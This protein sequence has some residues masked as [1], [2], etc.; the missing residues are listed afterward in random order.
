[1]KKLRHPNILLFMGAVM[2]PQRLCIVSEFLPRY[3]C[4]CFLFCGIFSLLH[5]Y[6]SLA[7]KFVCIWLMVDY[8]N[9]CCI[10][11]GNLNSEILGLV[12]LRSHFAFIFLLEVVYPVK[13]GLV[14]LHVQT[15]VKHPNTFFFV[16]FPIFIL[17]FQMQWKLVSL[18]SKER[19]QVGC[20]T[21]CPH[22]FRYC[23]CI[24]LVGNMTP[25]FT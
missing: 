1:M 6:M 9:N 14:W 24:F 21:A 23:K 15:T 4:K 12:K 10:R 13:V 17:S 3:V 25:L 5:I 16:H 18:T 22:G 7:K 2:S 20:E 11:K 8:N 19:Y